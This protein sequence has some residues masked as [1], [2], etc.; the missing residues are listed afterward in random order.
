MTEK[1]FETILQDLLET[2]GWVEGESDAGDLEAEVEPFMG[3]SVTTFEDAGVLT[4]NRGLVVRMADGSEFQVDIVQSRAARG[5]DEDDDQ[6]EVER[7]AAGRCVRCQ[8]HDC[9]CEQ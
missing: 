3:C 1:T 8:C 5:A 9:I 7:D 2:A 6:P 4:K